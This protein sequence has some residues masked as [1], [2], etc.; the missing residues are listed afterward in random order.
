LQQD[1]IKEIQI[2]ESVKK[3]VWFIFSA[4]GSQWPG[5]GIY[6]KLKIYILFTVNLYNNNKF[7]IFINKL[8]S[9]RNLLK[10]EVFANAIRKCDVILKPYGI[11]ITDILTKIDEKMCENALYAFIGIVAIQVIYYISKSYELV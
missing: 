11:N 6:L 10:F 4:L 3:P 7:I 2:C 5:M 1:S 8:K 9:G